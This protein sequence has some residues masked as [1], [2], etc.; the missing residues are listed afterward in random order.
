MEG[1][2]KAFDKVWQQDASVMDNQSNKYI[3]IN[4]GVQQVFDFILL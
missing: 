4:A 1:L 3:L 2:S